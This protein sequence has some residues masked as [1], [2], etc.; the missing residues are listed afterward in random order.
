MKLKCLFS[1]FGAISSKCLKTYDSR[2]PSRF[3]DGEGC[4]ST[5]TNVGVKNGPSSPGPFELKHSTTTF[6]A[7]R[8]R[9]REQNSG[10]A[11]F[12]RLP[13]HQRGPGGAR[14]VGR[15]RR[16]V[17]PGNRG[18]LEESFLPS[19][20]ARPANDSRQGA[21]QAGVWCREYSCS[22]WCVTSY[23]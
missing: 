14:V 11:A 5:L 2:Q 6:T 10:A 4:A 23:S 3:L 19:R 13:V 20:I 12:G 17:G 16:V 9:C 21:G 18:R 8:L 1:V 22:M 15:W 7:D